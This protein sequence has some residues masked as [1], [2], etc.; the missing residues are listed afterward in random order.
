M[1]KKKN[2]KTNLAIISFHKNGKMTFNA[3]KRTTAK[4][5]IFPKDNKHRQQICVKQ[6]FPFSFRQGR[7]WQ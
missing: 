6:F 7:L 4:N 3:V 1:D 5:S 2:F